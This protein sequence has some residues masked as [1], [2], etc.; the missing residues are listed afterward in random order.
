MAGLLGLVL[1]F[2]GY[3]CSVSFVVTLDLS[4][5]LK[6]V[7]TQNWE[8]TVE[9][10][11]SLRYAASFFLCRVPRPM[12]GET[13]WTDWIP[14]SSAHLGVAC[15]GRKY[16]LFLEQHGTRA[17]QVLNIFDCQL[18]AHTRPFLGVLIN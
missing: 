6:F 17:S 4:P 14:G 3:R 11:S 7:T 1:G 9:P 5:W 8:K 16:L 2:R 15:R 13:A 10:P 12:D 18:I